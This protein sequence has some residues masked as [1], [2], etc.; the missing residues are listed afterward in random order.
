[1]RRLVLSI[2]L[3]VLCIVSLAQ[4]FSEN[5]KHRILNAYPLKPDEKVKIDGIL[6]EPCWNEL[7]APVNFWQME[8]YTGQPSLT[9][10]SLKITYDNTGLYIAIKMFDP[11]PDSILRELGTRDVGENN[12]DVAA[13]FFDTY[14]DGQNAFGFMV[15]SS[16]IQTDAKYS[17]SIGQDIGWNAVWFSDTKITEDGWNAE[18]KIPY[19]AI[20]FPDKNEQEWGLNFIRIDRRHREK[21]T[22]NFFDKKIPGFVNQFG[23][24]A[25]LSRIKAPLRLSVTPYLSAYLQHFPADVEGK[26]NFS[27]SINGGMDLKLGLTES[28]TLDMTLIPDFGQVQ[29]DNLVLNLS[30]FEVKYEE[31]RQ[32]F[33]EGTELFNRGGIFYSRRI[34]GTPSGYYDAI[35]KYNNSLIKNPDRVQ[36]INATKISGR[37][38][39]GNGL[40]FFNAITSNMEAV[41]KDSLGNEKI[42]NTEPAA[43][44]NILVAEKNLPNNSYISFINTNVLRGN[45]FRNANVSGTDFKFINK[46]QKFSADGN[47]LVSHIWNKTFISNMAY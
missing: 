4:E 46:T 25:G 23:S 36:L 37:S 31:K 12:A 41:Y 3:F 32:F 6:D 27:N 14:H 20:R 30:P 28:Y 10:T 15:S 38:K 5:E 47:F 2:P 44:Y 43:N 17:S 26:S 19:S 11:H 16:G 40:G 21:S 9:K 35:Y 45:E 22:W 42:F 18:I 1:M 24:I 33:T 39:K 7:S 13:I 29:S 8:P 34:A